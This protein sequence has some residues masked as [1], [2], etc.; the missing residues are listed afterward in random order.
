MDLELEEEGRSVDNSD[1]T[2]ALNRL[3]DLPL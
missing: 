3:N 2:L 1:K